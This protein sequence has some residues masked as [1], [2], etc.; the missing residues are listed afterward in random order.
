M[1]IGGPHRVTVDP[2]GAN[3]LAPAPLN[4]VVDT[5]HH[6]LGRRKG[7]DQQA[8]QEAGSGARASGSTP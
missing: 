1:P 8:E 3:A 7:R 4:S 6:W 2:F 5:Q